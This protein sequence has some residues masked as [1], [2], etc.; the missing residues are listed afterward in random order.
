MQTNNHQ[1]KSEDNIFQI[2]VCLDTNDYAAVHAKCWFLQH[3]RDLT[4]NTILA[5]FEGKMILLNSRLHQVRHFP[6]RPICF[7]QSTYFTKFM[8][9]NR[10][11]HP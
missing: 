9:M 4:G 1:K 3:E 10:Y 5:I 6:L 7:L 2:H 8:N 11:R